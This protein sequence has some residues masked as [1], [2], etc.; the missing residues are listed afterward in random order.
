VSNFSIQTNITS[1]QAQN[2]LAASAAFQSQTINEVTSGLRIVNSGDDAAGL[3]VANAL[4]SDQAVLTQGIQNA[5]N[6]LAT[7]QTIDGGINNVTTLLDRASTLASQS[8]SGTFTGSRATLNSEF[9]SVV[10][11][12]SQEAQSI[13]LNAGGQFTQALSVFI[14]GGQAGDG[15]TAVQNGSVGIDLS[16]SAV[17]AASL[18]L[19]GTTATGAAGSD[20]GNG[21]AT[22]VANIL[23]NTANNA[24]AGISFNF[25]GAGF[26]DSNQQTLN[27]SLTGVT[28]TATLT[29]AINAAITAATT[30]SAG[31]TTGT[32]F[33]N[34]GI[35]VSITT[36]SAGK[37][38]LTF[39][40]ATAAFQVQAGDQTA[41]ALLGNFNTTA[42][43]A[44]TGQALA[45]TATGGSA[46][47]T[48]TGAA[49]TAGAT[50]AG[51]TLTFSGAGL[52]APV[53][54]NFVAAS[55]AAGF[56]A[57]INDV[58]SANTTNQ[59]AAIAL[60]AAGISASGGTALAPLVFTGSGALSVV[61]GGAAV[62]GDATA[63]GLTI[64][65]SPAPVYAGSANAVTL[66]VQGSG[67]ASPI[68]FVLTAGA[69]V[70]QDLTA[71]QSTTSP[72]GQALVAA[73]ISVSLNAT[74]QQ[75]SFTSATG[76]S[77][78]VTTSGDATNA[79]GFGSFVSTGT[80]AFNSVNGTAVGDGITASTTLGTGT[81][82][83]NG[84]TLQISI[85]GGTAISIST[86]AAVT[87]GG[88][89]AGDIQTQGLAAATT[90]NAAIQANATLKAAGLV[91]TS[92]LG[93][94]QIASNNGTAFR[95]NATT[96]DGIGGGAG[97]GSNVGFG[98]GNI[99]ST[100]STANTLVTDARVDSAGASSTSTFAYN[101]TADQTVTFTGND[102]SGTAHTTTISLINN[103]TT[104]AT[105]NAETIDQ[106]IASI[107]T[108]LQGT[109]DGT[110]DQIV[111]VKDVFV[112]GTAA[113]PVDT[114]GIKF[115]S[116]LSTF[117][118][119]LG[120]SGTAASAQ[121]IGTAAQQNASQVSSTGSQ[122]DIS[123]Q[124]GAEAAVALLAVAVTKLG[125]AQA[126]VGK[127][128]NDLNYAV[129]LATSQDTNEAAAESNIR[130]ADLATEA[131]NLSKAQ[132]LVQAG[133]AA[134]AQA[135]SA[136][137]VILSLLK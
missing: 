111:A 73:G 135:N 113:N 88:V 28:N 80:G 24:G 39:G 1:L 35:T 18:G 22:T 60:A 102:A 44:S 126:A 20:I 79:L 69:T 129:A 87:T 12:I 21:G 54:F 104:G 45:S 133:A 110:L 36:D 10:S 112:G 92:T 74:T 17:D 29:S 4:A 2:N 99:T 63:T 131:A 65:T 70:A 11:E 8:A 46:L 128:E 123:T 49:T 105:N 86:G 130:D 34:A 85:A 114:E 71:L 13:G 27:V 107:N 94:L 62:A 106:A 120:T 58:T 116:S 122:A 15:V 6:G 125:D 56:I 37:Q 33:A 59:A 48:L 108:Q 90:L 66:R 19:T 115:I 117:T 84:Q 9:Q 89:T 64:G 95:L 96:S 77:I 101:P 14:G 41:N 100:T 97:T 42:A 40:S 68:D 51:D 5:N 127:G 124:A 30:N 119:A 72:A 91:V 78:N 53:V 26:S 103:T 52:A 47:A 43:N 38:Q 16:K 132:I 82:V 76:G 137:Q 3:A 61:L 31:S 67:I 75:L 50:T 57:N 134:L 136:P 25:T 7:L 83:N 81:T 118:V 32:A 93:V 109:G 98:T 121:G 23:A 55:T